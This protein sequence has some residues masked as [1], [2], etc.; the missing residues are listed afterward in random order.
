MN[1]SV[2]LEDLDNIDVHWEEWAPAFLEFNYTL[3]SSLWKSTARKIK[4]HYL[5]GEHFN[6]E[7]LLKLIQIFSDRYFLND[8]ETAVRMQAKVNKSPVY[9]YLFGYPGDNNEQ[10]R[11]V[12]H[13]KDS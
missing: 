11:M 9:Y 12:F 3:S 5:G 13:L 8:A 7:N 2:F 1:F 10:K 4:E 6:K